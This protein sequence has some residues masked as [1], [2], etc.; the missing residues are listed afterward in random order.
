MGKTHSKSF[1]PPLHL[2][3]FPVQNV[4]P[5]VQLDLS[6]LTHVGKYLRT[7]TDFVNLMSVCKKYHSICDHFNFNP[8]STNNTKFFPNITKQ[9]LYDPSDE[10][11]IGDYDVVV[12]YCVTYDDYHEMRNVQCLNIQYTTEDRHF[13]GNDIPD[14]VNSLG[15]NYFT[16]KHITSIDIP[17]TVTSLGERCYMKCTY[18]KTIN[19]PTTVNS[20]ESYCFRNCWNATKISIPESVLRIGPGCFQNCHE[21]KS[22]ILP[23]S[24]STLPFDCFSDC[25]SLTS[26]VLPNSFIS[27]SCGCFRNC[28]KL[29]IIDIPTSVKSL[30]YDCFKNCICLKTIPLPNKIT[31]LGYGCFSNCI[32][33]SHVNISTNISSIGQNCFNGCTSLTSIDIPPSVTTIGKQCFEGCESLQTIILPTTLE[34]FYGENFNNTTLTKSVESGVVVYSDLDCNCSAQQLKRSNTFNT[35]SQ[36]NPRSKKSTSSTPVEDDNCVTFVVN[37]TAVQNQSVCIRE[38]L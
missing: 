7:E 12:H 2:H 19:I 11:F 30:G 28:S 20:I 31:S 23:S 33:L 9:H 13:Y 34:T 29:E 16:G 24:L 3:Q 15:F 27:I 10:L 35:N 4:S 8:I 6:S 21:L 5:S 37:N 18:L 22:V 36:R 32:S 17:T 1:S 38:S 14:C 26:V 25:T